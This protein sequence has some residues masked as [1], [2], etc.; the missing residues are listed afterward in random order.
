MR[1]DYLL[2]VVEGVVSSSV[3]VLAQ[4]SARIVVLRP[5]SRASIAVCTM[6]PSVAEPPNGSS[7]HPR[8]HLN[9]LLL[10]TPKIVE[11]LGKDILQ[12]VELH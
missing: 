10:G 12:R 11:L 4:A 5:C 8:Q 1:A 6:Q 7:G 3:C 9:K 2:G